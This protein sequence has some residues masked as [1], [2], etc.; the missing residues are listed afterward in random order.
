[1][2][3]ETLDLDDV[4]P[5]AELP[6]P[7]KDVVTAALTAFD[8]LTVDLR[9]IDRDKTSWVAISATGTGAT[10]VEAKKIQEKVSRWTY[11][12]PAYKANLIKIKLADLLEPAKGS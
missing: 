5:A 1:M 10:E 2:T 6:V 3:L 11:A 9:L 8:G 4:K 7:D 12:V